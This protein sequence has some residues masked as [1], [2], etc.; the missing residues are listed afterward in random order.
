MPVLCLHGW[1]QHWYVWRDVMPALAG[2]GYRVLAPDMRGSGWSGDPPDGDYRKER[3]ADDALA[4]LDAEGIERAGVI[5]HDW[6]AW[7]GFQLCARA[8]E[9]VCAFL[10]LGMARPWQPLWR[11]A[12]QLPRLGYQWP[13]ATPVVGPALVRH[14]AYVAAILRAAAAPTYDWDPA[15]LAGY[16]ERQ[17]P[18]ATSAL[19]RQIYTRG[20]LDRGGEPAPHALE[21]PVELLVGTHDPAFDSRLIA[22]AERVPGAGHFLVDECPALVVE[23]ARTLLRAC[24]SD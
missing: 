3:L 4:L 10:A 20:L 9:R 1:P 7:T 18:G 6:G 22:D 21:M 11:W 19:Y 8:P 15:V 12:L 16:V 17:R 14:G 24:G 23:R 2:D 5:G 13:L